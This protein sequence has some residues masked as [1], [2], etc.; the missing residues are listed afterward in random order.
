MGEQRVIR[1]GLSPG[2]D[3]AVLR[4]CE[5][6]KAI[7]RLELVELLSTASASVAATRRTHVHSFGFLVPHVFVS[8]VLARIGAC[9]GV[10]AEA[11]PGDHAEVH[12]LVAA[13]ERG[14]HR[15]DPETK[16]LVKRSFLQESARQPFFER[17]KPF[18]GPKLEACLPAG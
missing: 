15:G 16:D 5:S 2:L 10:G 4:R 8:E 6:G 11:L 12:A 13:M 17:L 7:N 18:I 1:R 9:L 3:G 14:M